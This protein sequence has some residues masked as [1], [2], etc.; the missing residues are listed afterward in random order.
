[1]GLLTPALSHY[2]KKDMPRLVHWSQ[3]KAD[4][5]M[6]QRGLISVIPAKATL[7]Q[8]IAS[9]LLDKWSQPKAA[10]PDSD[11]MKPIDLWAE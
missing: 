7:D 3:E 9:E 8:P 6:D 11:Q 5:N 1:M 2:Q 10:K 4:K